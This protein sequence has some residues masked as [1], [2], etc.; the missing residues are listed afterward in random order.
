LPAGIV[1]R[2]EPE[3]SGV[4]S[5]L[6]AGV[7]DAEPEDHDIQIEVDLSELEEKLA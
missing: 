1:A 5:L 6:P 7:A 3:P 2:E 4:I